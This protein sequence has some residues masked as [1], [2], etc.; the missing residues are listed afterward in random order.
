MQNPASSIFTKSSFSH[1][2]KPDISSS[3]RTQRNKTSIN[4]KFE[5]PSPLSSFKKTLLHPYHPAILTHP[6]HH[7]S[8]PPSSRAV[9]FESA[10]AR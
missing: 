4:Q 5:I 1:H 3:K 2:N 8:I 6:P 10:Q 9:M 7:P